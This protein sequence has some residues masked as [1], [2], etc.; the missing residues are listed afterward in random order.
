MYQ[1]L[2]SV[3][4]FYVYIPMDFANFNTAIIN[5]ERIYLRDLE[6]RDS[7][8]YA[9]VCEQF[10]SD[11]MLPGLLFGAQVTPAIHG[12]TLKPNVQQE[13]VTLSDPNRPGEMIIGRRMHFCRMMDFLVTDFFEGLQV[14]HAPKQCAVCGRYFLT[15]N[16]RPRKYCDGYAPGDPRS[17]SCQQVGARK[18]RS[19]RERADDHPVKIVCEK[20][21]NTIDHH[22]RQGKI[23]R[24]FAKKA[25]ALARNK[26]DKALRDNRYF[27][28]EY[29]KE[30]AQE[31]IYAETQRLLGRPPTIQSAYE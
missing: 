22:L 2:L 11:Q 13:F 17:R 10:F 12:F 21:C 16:A 8:H 5:L 30:M 24:E 27:V 14:G 28:S 3:L 20:R 4:N 23:D 19:E 25:K 6:V 29:E 7:N 18:Q 31:A 1:F 15:T 9:Q 26:R